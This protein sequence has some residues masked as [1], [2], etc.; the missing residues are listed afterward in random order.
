MVKMK[1]TYFAKIYM[2][3]ML[4]IAGNALSQMQNES[5]SRLGRRERAVFG[6]SRF[7]YKIHNLGSDDRTQSQL[8]LYWSFVHDILQF[9]KNDN[10]GYSAKFNIE[11]DLFDE[12]MNH[13]KN[14][15]QTDLIPVESYSQTNSTELTRSGET[16]FIAPPGKYNLRIELTDM[17]TQKSLTRKK[18]IELRD[19]SEPKLCLSDV[20]FMDDAT[21]DST[22]GMQILPNLTAN[23]KNPDSDFSAY[24]EIYPS[25]KTDSIDFSYSVID[26]YDKTAF[27]T[28]ISFAPIKNILRYKLNLKQA[29]RNAGRY[30]LVIR[31]VSNKQKAEIKRRFFVQWGKLPQSLYNIDQAIGPLKILGN[32]EELKNQDSATIDEKEAAFNDFWTKRD[33][34]PETPENEYKTEFY[35][36]VDICNQQFTVHMMD[37][38]GW[39]TD[40]GRV[41]L[42]YGEPSQVEKQ[43]IDI[44]RPAVEIWYYDQ[45]HQRFIFA[46]RSGIGDYKLVRTE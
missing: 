36:R 39:A 31:A 33:P 5:E 18:E 21:F 10:G 43:S 14:Y 7:I 15:S 26:S 19:F 40:R 11:I 42:K 1:W 41:Y 29:I 17:D 22:G 27:D 24:I 3:S 35:R 23:F 30:Y 8:L 44:N 45:L 13:M 2:I 16:R 12:H 28:T 34:T 25:T 32:A 37:K 4:L 38:Q 9:V 46:D 20:I 6:M